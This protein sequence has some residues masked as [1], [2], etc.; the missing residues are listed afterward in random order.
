MDVEGKVGE[1]GSWRRGLETFCPLY[2]RSWRICDRN[3]ITEVQSKLSNRHKL[4]Y[5]LS[6]QAINVA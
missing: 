3:G 1:F 4:V 6:Q 5:I 2:F